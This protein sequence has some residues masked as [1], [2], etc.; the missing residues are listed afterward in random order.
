MKALIDGDIILYSCG[1]AS[2]KNTHYVHAKGGG[3]CLA[4]FFKKKEMKEWLEA[5]GLSL[6][7]V[8]VTT[9]VA[10]DP[11]G[12]CM[13]NVDSSIA[14][15]L[16]EVGTT[17]YTIFLTG[18]DNFREKVAVSHPYKGNRD[19]L[20]KPIHYEAIRYHLIKHHEAVVVDGQEADD[21]MGIAQ[22]PGWH[23]YDTQYQDGS[24][25]ETIICSIDKDM[26]MIPG[27]HFHTQKRTKYYVDKE[28]ALRWFHMQVLMGDAVDNIKGITGIGPVKAGD[29]V[30]RMDNGTMYEECLAHYNKAFEEESGRDRLHENMRLLWIRRYLNQPPP[31]PSWVPIEERLR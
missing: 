15:I 5:S 31:F 18:K 23:I 29:I 26:D 25:S 1:F 22:Y 7:N 4:D 24:L 19:K 11:V 3:Q 28:T 14:S 17:E 13:S 12:I 2:Q 30:S 20:H 16:Q 9:E 27:W 10:A 6:D 21:A 8:D